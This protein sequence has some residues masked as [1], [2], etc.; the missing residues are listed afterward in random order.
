MNYD[1]AQAHFTRSAG[2]DGKKDTGVHYKNSND[3]IEEK[4]HLARVKFK[5]VG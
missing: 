1:Q 3:H 5:E 4:Q 2:P